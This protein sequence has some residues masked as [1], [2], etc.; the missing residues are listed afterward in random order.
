MNVVDI[1]EALEADNSRLAKEAI[2]E[3]HANNELLKRIFQI[4]GD[5]FA[6][7]GV[8]KFKMPS[9]PGSASRYCDGIDDVDAYL[10]QESD[11]EISKFIDL[12]DR[13]NVRELSGNAAKDAVVNSFAEMLELEQKWC[14]RILL[15]NMRCGVSDNLVEKFWPGLVKKFAVSLAEPLEAKV[16]ENHDSPRGYDVKINERISYPVYADRKIDGFRCVVIKKD[17]V[18]EMFSRNGK[19]FDTLPTIKKVLEASKFDNFVLDCEAMCDNWEMSAS[20]LLSSKN[21][22]DDSQIKINVFDTMTITEWSSQ[23]C[24]TWFGERISNVK[25]IV[26]ALNHPNI[27]AVEGKIISNEPELL[28]FFFE[29]LEAGFE[30]VMLKDLYSPY[31]FERSKAI[32]K[33]KPVT[34]HELVVVGWYQGHT[35]TKREGQFGGFI[36]LSKDGVTTRCGGGWKD[37]QRAEF[38]LVGPETYYGKIMEIKGQFLT[39]DLKVRFPVF[40]RWREECD[41]DPQVVR[42]YEAHVAKS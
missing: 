4:V 41:V 33:F 15:R 40:K 42:A 7:F 39:P 21:L 18:V 3:Q 14:H 13:L 34:T 8:V 19:Q 22:K 25:T 32:R 1:L 10:S 36:G 9:A 28:E 6:N 37:A 26:A 27:V 5:P 35:N 2:L 24:G 12:L 16:V 38:Q 31:V 23:L 17:G 20:V 30:G 29:S 11:R